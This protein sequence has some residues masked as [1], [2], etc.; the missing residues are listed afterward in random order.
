MISWLNKTKWKSVLKLN[1]VWNPVFRIPKSRFFHFLS[2][3]FFF[4]ET[5]AMRR[6]WAAT[7]FLDNKDDITDD[8]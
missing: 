7:R 5:A 1:P 3:F 4:F 6:L 8:F 2:F